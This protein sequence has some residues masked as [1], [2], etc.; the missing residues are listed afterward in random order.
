LGQ[1][2]AG[3]TF[4]RVAKKMKKKEEPA[5]PLECRCHEYSLYISRY[6]CRDRQNRSIQ[7]NGD[8]CDLFV[9]LNL[10][11]TFVLFPQR[12]M[13]N[14]KY[15][16]RFLTKKIKEKSDMVGCA[17][18]QSQGIILETGRAVNIYIYIYISDRPVFVKVK[19]SKSSQYLRRGV[20]VEASR[21]LSGQL[22][23]LV[24]LIT[25]NEPQIPI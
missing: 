24:V 4:V 20:M 22:H 12:R 1:P 9:F 5:N 16:L 21:I 18:K 13:S 6:G 14:L 23:A 3:P 19:I 25:G 8:F 10:R 15:A 11:G 17:L 7:R 2:V